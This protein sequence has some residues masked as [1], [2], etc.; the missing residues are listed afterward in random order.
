MQGCGSQILEG[1]GKVA[2]LRLNA[3]GWNVLVGADTKKI[4]DAVN[5]F[6]PPQNQSN[7]F[8]DGKASEEIKRILDDL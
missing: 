6:T 3:V 7:H 2:H 8:G 4:V 5:E 1:T